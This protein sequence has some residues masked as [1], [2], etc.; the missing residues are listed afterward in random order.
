VTHE[1]RDDE[2][3]E[4]LADAISG[5]EKCD[6][7]GELQVRAD[8][9]ASVAVPIGMSRRTETRK[10]V[11]ELRPQIKEEERSDRLRDKCSTSSIARE[12]WYASHAQKASMGGSPSRPAV[13]ASVPIKPDADWSIAATAKAF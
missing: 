3:T 11:P 12:N 7:A 13:P 9:Q 1:G 2:R 10:L 4:N 8:G 5:C 6:G